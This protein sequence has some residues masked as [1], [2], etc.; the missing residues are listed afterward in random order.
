VNGGTTWVA[1]SGANGLSIGTYNSVANTLR[2]AKTS[3]LYTDTITS[4]SFR[5]VSSNSAVY[6]TVS[7]AKIYDVVDLQIGGRN[8]LKN[9]NV[10]ISATKDSQTGTQ[11]TFDL[12]D[13]YD[14]S[15]LIAS[16]SCSRA[17]EE[18]LAKRA[19]AESNGKVL[20]LAR[21]VHNLTYPNK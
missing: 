20:R 3:T 10:L 21:K 13:K 14:V 4:I 19:I 5:C 18:I 17:G 2:I 15:E 1:A 7:I 9:T 11:L 6:D 12:V 8:L 16:A